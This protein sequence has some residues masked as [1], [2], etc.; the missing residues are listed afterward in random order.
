MIM[1]KKLLI[2]LIKL[3]ITDKIDPFKYLKTFNDFSD[4]EL[5][6]TTEDVERILLLL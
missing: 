1:D 3:A 4:G 2:I 5:Q 6:Y